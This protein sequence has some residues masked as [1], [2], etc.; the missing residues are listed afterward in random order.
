MSFFPKII[1][2]WNKLPHRIIES[3][4]LMN[5]LTIFTNNLGWTSYICMSCACFLELS[6]LGFYQLSALIAYPSIK[7][8]NQLMLKSVN[9]MVP[10]WALRYLVEPYVSWLVK[11]S[12]SLTL[13]QCLNLVELYVT[14]LN[15]TLP[16]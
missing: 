13:V 9:L 2:D 4:S 8:I 7:S 16:G 5:S 10:G 15:L 12:V 14:W 1:R 6:S 3:E 11:P